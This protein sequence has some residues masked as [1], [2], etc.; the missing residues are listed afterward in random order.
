RCH[1]VAPRLHRIPQDQFHRRGR[2][3]PPISKRSAIMK[4]KQGNNRPRKKPREDAVPPG[5]TRKAFDRED[6]GGGPPGSPLG[7]RHAIGDPAGGSEIGGL[8]GSNID[9][10]SPIERGTDLPSE[11]QPPYSGPPVAAL[12]GTPAGGRCTG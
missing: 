6:L 11:A 4:G 2:E 12:G 1:L 8:G 7:D 3:R 9:D 10:G 5:A